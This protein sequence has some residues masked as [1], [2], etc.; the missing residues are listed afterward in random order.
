MSFNNCAESSTFFSSLD[1]FDAMKLS[2]GKQHMIF[3]GQKNPKKR[4]LSKK[5]PTGPT[6]R[7][8]KPEHLIALVTS[9]GVRW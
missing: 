8:P 3:P 7:T 5:S 9:L 2:A 1:G 6:E 4:S